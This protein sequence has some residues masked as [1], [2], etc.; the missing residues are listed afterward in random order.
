[1]RAILRVMFRELRLILSDQHIVTLVL[2]GPFF[3][4]LIFG[5]VY[6]HGRVNQ[7]SI[8]VVDQDH[9]ALSRDL[10]T[11]LDASD[12]LRVAI[13]SGTM[14][15]FDDAV[16][17]GSVYLCVVIPPDFQR[18]LM[19]G[20]QATVL[21]DIDGCNLLISNV[22]GRAVRTVLGTYR[23]G[24]RFKRL[25]M[26]GAPRSA[27]M[28]QVSPITAEYRSLYNP[29]FN[30]S[31][32]L[33][34]GLTCIALQQV[35]ML[36]ASIALGMENSPDRR[37]EL[38]AITRRPL[39]ILTGKTL[40]FLV[41]LLPLG[42]TALY[43]PFGL[44]GAPFRGSWHFM[45][46]LMMFYIFMHVLLGFFME[47]LCKSSV[48]SAQILLCISTPAFLLTG[49]TWPV[50]AMP[51]WV[52]ALSYSLPLTH[53]AD[54]LRKVSLM[55]ASIG[56]FRGHILAI[57]AWLPVAIAGGYWAVWR[58]VRMPEDAGRHQL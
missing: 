29:A 41:P 26:Q 57:M 33:L 11:A 24:A 55:G 17:R 14:D 18:D 43:V 28:S 9:S 23:V 31:T 58:L 37:R 36:S 49:A 27:L 40:A 50:I 3:Y 51:G 19:R 7:V 39:Q 38:L 2:G 44:F 48:F 47:G 21:V 20:R 4:C 8:A 52:Q 53:Y 6:L 22:T 15:A 54:M 12:S 45:A 42:I 34:M 13:R 46:G 56:L 10:T 25:M 30:Y 5:A 32:Y 1:M 16:K 35:T